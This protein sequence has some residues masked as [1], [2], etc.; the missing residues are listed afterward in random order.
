MAINVHATSVAHT[1][2]LPSDSSLNP[3]SDLFIQKVVNMDPKKLSA[4]TQ[5]DGNEF[6]FL[7]LMHND[8][9]L[10]GELHRKNLPF[11]NIFF[12]LERISKIQYKNLYKRFISKL[13][14]RSINS[15]R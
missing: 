3:F 4:I 15:S 2:F 11:R 6:L 10:V 1:V 8:D 5:M 12:L 13:L 9:I 14:C 7:Q